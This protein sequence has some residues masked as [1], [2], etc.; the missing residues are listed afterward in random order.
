MK[1]NI[2]PSTG[3]T[4]EDDIV[5]TRVPRQHH[6]PN[7]GEVVM[8]HHSY[9]VND[10]F[11]VLARV[12]DGYTVQKVGATK[13]EAFD[14]DELCIRAIVQAAPTSKACIKCRAHKPIGTFRRGFNTCRQCEAAY[15]RGH[16][17]S[18]KN[19]M[20]EAA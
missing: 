7:L 12:P 1:G 15:Q 3:A 8:V 6:T 18:L 9:S 17:V 19:R 11:I 13:S 5:F 4:L 16:Y 14:V 10:R 2:K 20:R